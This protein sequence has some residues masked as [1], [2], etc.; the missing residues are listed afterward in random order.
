MHSED[1]KCCVVVEVLGATNADAALMKSVR[2]EIES[3]I[4]L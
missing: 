1:W 3:F 4:V 2:A